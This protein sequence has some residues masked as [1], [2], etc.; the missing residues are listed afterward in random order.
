MTNELSEARQIISPTVRLLNLNNMIHPRRHLLKR[1]V[2]RVA[3]KAQRTE[4]EILIHRVNTLSQDL[5]PT[6]LNHCIQL[7]V[8]PHLLCYQ[9]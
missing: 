7:A 4:N 3:P 5:L 1:N 9:T 2:D 8:G 6:R